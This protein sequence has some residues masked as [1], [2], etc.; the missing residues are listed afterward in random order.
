MGVAVSAA[1]V[2]AVEVR[3]LSRLQWRPLAGW[4]DLTHI[5]GRLLVSPK[6]AW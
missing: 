5:K 2:N 6:G 3:V 1:L 4:D